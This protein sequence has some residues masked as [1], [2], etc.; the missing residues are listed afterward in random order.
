MDLSGAGQQTSALALD[1]VA[2]SETGRRSNNEDSA[3]ASPRMAVVADG[4][5]GA[6]AGEIA[7]VSIVNALVSLDKRRLDDELGRELASAVDWG[8][9]AIGLVTTAQPETAGMSTTLSAVAISNEGCF[10]V[11]NVGDSRSYLLRQGRLE[12]LTSDESLVGELVR[13]GQITPEQAAVHPQ[14]SV[15][16]RALDGGEEREPAIH[17]LRAQLGDRVLVCSDGLSDYVSDEAIGGLLASG[18]PRRAAEALIERALDCESRDNVS[19]VVA[20]VIE[21]AE[22]AWV[23]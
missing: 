23:K 2:M 16:M 8:N 19:V 6:A 13:S 3:F 1:G 20:D 11:A 22:P 4:V 18:D 10:V 9:A 12:Q 21:A 5:G 14:R 7:S 15:V 17:S